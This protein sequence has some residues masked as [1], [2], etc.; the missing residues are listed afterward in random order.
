MRPFMNDFVVTLQLTASNFQV[1]LA[2]ACLH[3]FAGSPIN[4]LW[5]SPLSLSLL[6]QSNGI[7]LIDSHY[8]G[9][10]VQQEVRS[11]PAVTKAAIQD[12]LNKW[13]R[14]RND[15]LTNRK[16][17]ETLVRSIAP[18]CTLLVTCVTPCTFP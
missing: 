8:A 14:R 15:R 18:S 9:L 13:H 6:L 10:G 4:M 1:C 12:F 2:D 17:E 11:A 7:K 3:G 5:P 16:G